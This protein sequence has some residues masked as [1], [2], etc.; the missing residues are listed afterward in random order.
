MKFIQFLLSALVI[1]FVFVSCSE[2]DVV[3]KYADKSFS[4]ILSASAKEISFNSKGNTWTFESPSGDMLI[5][6]NDFARNTSS[7][8][9]MDMDK[10][11]IELIFDAEPF[12]SA[13]LDISKIPV[14]DGIKYELE[15]GKF[16]YHFELSSDV[17]KI[18][19]TRS[20][21]EVFKEIIRTQRN[22]ISYHEALDH[23]GIKLLNGNMFEWAK[24]LAKNDKDIVFVLNPEPLIQA[25][26]NPLN[27]KGWV[28][29][30]VEM[31]D[32]QGKIVL[33][34]KLLKPFN[35]K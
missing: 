11:D 27:L 29:A 28:F 17:F 23:Y 15:D 5:F 35:L 19:N 32:E 34:D 24:D 16:M 20:F 31:K 25:G 8:G 13:G 22:R 14:T 10:P 30:K 7:S 12:L 9:L 3:A 33:V 21:K 4:E 1:T 6:S 26:L 2:I 18:D